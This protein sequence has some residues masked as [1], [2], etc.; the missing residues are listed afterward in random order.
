MQCLR[1]ACNFYELYGYLN[2]PKGLAKMEVFFPRFDVL[3]GGMR[4]RGRSQRNCPFSER[5]SACLSKVPLRT[6]WLRRASLIFE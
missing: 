1:M 2:L 6:W 3:G 5:S 4:G